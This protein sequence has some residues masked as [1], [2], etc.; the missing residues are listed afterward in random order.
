MR[1]DS[2]LIALSIIIFIAAM[3]LGGLLFLPIIVTS[4][5]TQ[6]QTFTAYLFTASI[7]LLAVVGI[8]MF[9]KRKF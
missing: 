9:F 4:L 7:V 5:K 6:I 3:L 1:A 2:G 8:S